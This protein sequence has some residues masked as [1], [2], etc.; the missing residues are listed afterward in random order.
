MT[1]SSDARFDTSD[2]ECPYDEEYLLAEK[3][4]GDSSEFYRAEVEDDDGYDPYSDRIE[5]EP[6]FSPDPWA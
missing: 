5:V 6:L 1:Y 2:S 3:L 4:A